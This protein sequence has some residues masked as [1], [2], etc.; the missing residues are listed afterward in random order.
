MDFNDE[1]IR[2]VS[3]E[4]NK[5][6]RTWCFY[7]GVLSGVLATLFVLGFLIVFGL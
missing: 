3:K 2:W 6:Q 7:I 4:D 5:T 1:S